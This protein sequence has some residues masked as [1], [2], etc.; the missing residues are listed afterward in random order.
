MR[1]HAKAVRAA[2]H[3]VVVLHLAGP[4][5][6]LDGGLWAMEAEVDPSL[7]EGIET[8]HVSHRSF[9]RRGT[10]YGFY[11]W[12]A[13]GA[14]RR[15][16]NEGFRPDVIHAHVYVAGVPAALV[17]TGSGIPLVLTEH[18]T[19]FPRRMLST[20]EVWKARYAYHRAAR[21]LPVSRDLRDAIRSYG[22]DARF[23]VVPNVVDT[24]LFFAPT[25]R[26]RAD[27][28]VRRL[29]F[30]GNLEPS[31]H[32]GFPTLLLA[33]V[34]LCEHRRD[35]RLDVVGDGPERFAYEA[36]AAELGLGDLVEFHGSQ[37]KSV[38]AEMM[39][40]AD[41]FVL[42]SRFETFGAAIAEALASGLPVVSTT[43]GAIPELVDERNGRL[44]PPDDPSAL[45][46]AVDDTLGGIDA[47]DHR[48]IAA[49]ARERFSPEV[50]GERLTQIYDSVLAAS[51]AN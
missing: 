43:V 31:Q 41:L 20:I 26:R 19:G 13:I 39:R 17:A 40:A 15:L 42:P 35:W 4:H 37:S 22:I 50:V 51:R 11:L 33:L 49:T 34:R 44:V 5:P 38:I 45:A 36:S 6:E 27:N 48:A 2:G 21:T 28:G 23:E 24:S 25:A 14:Y 12:S 47:F 10:S 18:T 29:L 7:S 8:Y 1:E 9:R 46:D 32:K 30:V 3:D 16:R